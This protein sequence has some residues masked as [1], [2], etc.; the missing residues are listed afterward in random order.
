VVIGTTR[1][2]SRSP[3][4]LVDDV[5]QHGEPQRKDD[6]ISTLHSTSVVD[7]HNR[8]FTDRGG[9]SLCRLL[10]GALELQGFATGCEL[11]R[12]S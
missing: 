11:T 9:Q 7:G 4:A 12:D 3:S 10:V 5:L 8:G 6:R 1:D 2:L